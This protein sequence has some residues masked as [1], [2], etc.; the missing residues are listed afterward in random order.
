M[1]EI[2]QMLGIKKDPSLIL[3]NESASI[4]EISNIQ[5][6]KDYA[7]YFLLHKIN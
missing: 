4:K 3:K 6:E 7:I 1:D 5:K 2:E